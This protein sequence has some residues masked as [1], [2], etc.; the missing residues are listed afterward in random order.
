MI[1]LIALDLDGTLLMDDHVTVSESNIKAITLAAQ[2]GIIITIASGRTFA[3]MR[4]VFEQLPVARFAVFSNG[5]SAVEVESGKFVIENRYISAEDSAKIYDAICDYRATYQVYKEKDVYTDVNQVEDF[6]NAI[7]LL[8]FSEF[9]IRNTI[10]ESTSKMASI[11]KSKVEKYN[12]EYI[13]PEFKIQMKKRLD[14][15]HSLAITSSYAENMEIFSN[16]T[17][18]GDALKR[19]CE[20]QSI[21]PSEV[22]AFGDSGND[23]EML[24]WAGL[25]YAMENANAA[26]KAAAKQITDSNVEDGVGKAISAYLETALPI[27]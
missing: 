1:K 20:K 16:R 13:A 27:T 15:L 10:I 5:A 18:K 25:S 19:L 2:K 3:T 8:A 17:N 14:A 6:H 11:C 22:M 23:I 7:R 9:L 4:K 26:V 12:I 21:L 24:K